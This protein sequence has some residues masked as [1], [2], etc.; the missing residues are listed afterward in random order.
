MIILM[1]VAGA[2][3]SLQG[4]MFVDDLGYHWVSS[5]ELF[6]SQLSED[7]KKE[8]LTGKL[9]RDDEVIELVSNT[10]D[11]IND[12]G[13]VV[14]DGV[15]RTIPQ[16]EW[17]LDQIKQD[18]LN[19]QAVFNLT[20]SKEV[21]RKRLLDRGRADDNEKIIDERFNEYETKT[22]PI[23]DFFRENNLKVFDINA[24][25]SPETVH[26]EMLKHIS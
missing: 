12:S 5:G 18:K 2:G 14:L 1:G 11:N 26:R 13:H 21:V 4:K 24:D 9:I 20:I 10:L 16:A 17:I 23:I 3:K 8:L 15:P 19:V 25:Q 7:R 6:R 22:I